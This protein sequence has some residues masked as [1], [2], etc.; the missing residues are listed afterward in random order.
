MKPPPRLAALFLLAL[1]GV[2]AAVG[3]LVAD[4][5]GGAAAAAYSVVVIALLL[6]AAARAR[7]ALRPAQASHEGCACCSEKPFAG[8]EVI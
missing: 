3:L 1:V 2:L 7:I 5:A 4:L 8:V 6:F